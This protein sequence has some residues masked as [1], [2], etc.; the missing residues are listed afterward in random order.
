LEGEVAVSHIQIKKKDERIRAFE[1]EI[2]LE[3]N[4][5]CNLELDLKRSRL[6]AEMMERSLKDELSSLQRKLNS[7]EE[8]KI[9]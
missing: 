7:V 9:I 1:E 6:E 4:K 8:H 5:F 2:Y 3:K